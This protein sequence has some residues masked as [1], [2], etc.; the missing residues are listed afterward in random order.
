M[1]PPVSDYRA[2][3]SGSANGTDF[4][5]AGI[6]PDYGFDSV[7]PRPAVPPSSGGRSQ[8]L[9]AEQADAGAIRDHNRG[10]LCGFQA[11]FF[12][13]TFYLFYDFSQAI[14]AILP[15]ILQSFF[16]LKI[17]LK[18]IKSRGSVK[19]EDSLPN[20]INYCSKSCLL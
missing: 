13:E 3:D 5:A 19:L 14:L 17:S 6:F 11:N 4:G 15:Q 12:F 7:A 10:D 16:D 1:P 18:D 9:V 20:E 2:T 8:W